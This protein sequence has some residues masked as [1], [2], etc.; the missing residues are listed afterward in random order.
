MADTDWTDLALDRD[1]WQAIANM[2]KLR[3]AKMWR[4]CWL[5]K[6]LVFFS[7]RLYFMQLAFIQ[8][9]TYH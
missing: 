5:T 3:F 8:L 7:E 4:V 1:T 2:V 6:K 9:A